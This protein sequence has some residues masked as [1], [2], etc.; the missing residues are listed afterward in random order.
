MISYLKGVIAGVDKSNSNRVILTLDVNQIGYDLQISARFAEELPAVGETVQVFTH[1]QMREEQ[2]LLYGF[3]STAQRDLFRQ[4]ISV[5]GIG[6]QLAIALLDT[7][8]LPD[9]VQA[10]VSGNTQLLIQAPGVGGRTAERISLE[11]KKKLADWRT[12][13]GV[14]AVTSGGPPPAI[15]EDV[16]MTLLALGYSASEVSQAITA[17]SDSVIL[18]QNANAEDWIRQAIAHLSG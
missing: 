7:L 12:T 6:A 5:S 8:D 4:L 18:Q 10:I 14:V 1:L 3:S 16:Q 17:V 11:L 9:L 15:L 2:P 13:T